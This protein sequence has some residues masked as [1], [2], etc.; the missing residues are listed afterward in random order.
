[1]GVRQN[2]PLGLYLHLETSLE[3]GFPRVPSPLRLVL[4]G[5]LGTATSNLRAEAHP[6]AHPHLGGSNPRL[7]TFKK[8]LI[9]MQVRARESEHPPKRAVIKLED[10][11]LRLIDKAKQMHKDVAPLFLKMWTEVHA[12]HKARTNSAAADSLGIASAYRSA[13]ADMLAWQRAFPKYYSHTLEARQAT[14]DEFGTLAL[15]IIYQYMNWRKAPPGFSGHTRGIAVDLTTRD[16]GQTWT[17][18]SDHGHQVGWQKTWLY[19]WLVENAWKHKFYQLKSET[20]HWEYH[21]DDPPRQCWGGHVKH[22]PV[23]KEK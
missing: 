7:E 18:N 6:S 20:W 22:R 2:G 21:Q 13:E 4:P 10:S 1:M 15:R 12:A 11:E 5:P 23:P 3:P 19:G 16:K 17:V 9:A 8:A 14:G